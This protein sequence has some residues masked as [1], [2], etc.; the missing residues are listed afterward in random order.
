MIVPF[1]IT[2]VLVIWTAVVYPYSR[3]GGNWAIY[4]AVFALPAILLW[5]IGLV[6]A[7]TNRGSAVLYA[8]V[9]SAGFLLVWVICL[10]LIS[11]DSL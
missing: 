9:N 11:K 1:V 6:V 5:D 8:I 7:S 3:Y 2:A 4:P 10:H